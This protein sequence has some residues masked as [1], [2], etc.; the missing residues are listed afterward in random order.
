MTGRWSAAKIELDA[1]ARLDA[2][3]A[4][5]H[6]ALLSLWPLLE[7]PR[8]EL[9]ALRDSLLRWKAATGPTDQTSVTADH[10]PA[11]PYLRPYLLGLVSARLGDLAAALA[12]A[13]EL[14]RRAGSSFAPAFVGDLGQVLIAEVAR[15]RG[16]PQEA[17]TILDSLEVWK[18][19]ELDTTG[20]SPFFSR[21]REQFTRAE[22]LH[23]LGRDGEALKAYRVIA[24]LVHSGAP[25]H[26][27]LA[28]I[29]QR[30][31]ERQK[32]SAHYGR[33]AELWKD[34]DP[35]LRPLVEEAR[36]RMAK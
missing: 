5:E 1:A 21:E 25:A 4:L 6:R 36:R 3:T 14:E 23:A 17:L 34:C 28:E 33:F 30:Q 24:H 12:Y 7:V 35:E 11:H 9:L 13:A 8:P 15:A 22:L 20:D 26:L 16:R 18:D 19:G 31:G 29:Y 32:A 2:A 27:R 10:A